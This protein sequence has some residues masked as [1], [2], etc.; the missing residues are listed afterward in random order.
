M[1]EVQEKP[2]EVFWRRLLTKQTQFVM[3]L[4]VLIIAFLLA[5]TI[6]FE[7]DFKWFW[8]DVAIIQF[9]WV[10]LLQLAA[11]LFTGVYS[12]VWKYV[13]LSE[14]KAFTRAVAVSSISPSS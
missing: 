7:F 12:F 11:F 6:R 1:S 5:Y 4:F 2:A 14:L 13:G 10:V 3:D 9:P 8:A